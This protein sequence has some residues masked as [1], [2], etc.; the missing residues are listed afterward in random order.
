MSIGKLNPVAWMEGMFLR[1]QHLQQHDLFA[2]ARL[3]YHLHTL[4]PFHW[5]VR[6]LAFDEEALAEN[7]IVVTRL[8]AVLRD[9]TL[10]R[11]PGNATVESR[12]FK[13]GIERL[14]VHLA[15]RSLSVQDANVGEEEGSRS[16][17]FRIAE[18]QLPDLTQG[19][20]TM[21]VDVLAPTLRLLVSGEE[22]ELGLYEAFKLAEIEAT[23]DSK[24]P[25]ALA[26]D[27]APP[28]LTLQASPVLTEEFTKV[29]SLVAARVRAVAA[30]TKTLSTDSVPR[31]FMRYTLSRTAP[32]LRHLAS[33]GETPPF[34][35]YTALVELAGA[36]CSYRLEE[37]VEL[38]VYDHED[39]YR[40]FMALFAFV[41]NELDKL[42]PENFSK[43]PL[44]FDAGAQA[45]VTTAL[46]M[47]LVDP[48]NAF[49]LAVKAPI[50]SKELVDLVA[51]QG[52]ASS[53]KGVAP[54]VKFAVPG[55]PIEPLPGAPTEIEGIAGHH[56]FRVD[57]HAREWAKVREDFS[58][59]LHLGKL[60]NASVLLYVAMAPETS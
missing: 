13:T 23:D 42:A 49:Y 24:R 56:Y 6:D 18:A 2:D 15:L 45:Y 37:A 25:F 51:E 60:Q 9:G 53:H 10:V 27:F 28:L 59:A 26:T 7:R 34:A 17:R 31:L 38:P 14:D 11:V 16:A 8:E 4:N 5:G 50:E 41:A 29:T 57:A 12:T 40:C 21:G 35:L 55:L 48:R 1:P 52:K 39:P 44:E 46:N 58:F 30:M 33:T 20:P 36:L 54:L 3:H 43:L 22:N 19:G 47:Q 32:L